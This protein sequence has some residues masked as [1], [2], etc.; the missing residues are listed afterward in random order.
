MAMKPIWPS[1]NTPVKP[2]ARARLTARI[3][4]MPMSMTTLT[5]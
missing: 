4:F 3:T 5:R 2:L 1:E